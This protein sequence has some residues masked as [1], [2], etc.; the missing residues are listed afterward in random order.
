MSNEAFDKSWLS[1]RCALCFLRG[2]S[3]LQAPCVTKGRVHTQP[4]DQQ[5][6]RLTTFMET[7]GPL[8]GS[9][10]NRCPSFLQASHEMSTHSAESSAKNKIRKDRLK[11][12]NFWARQRWFFSLKKNLQP[13]YQPLAT[14]TW[15]GVIR[16]PTELASTNGLWNVPQ[17]NKINVSAL[18]SC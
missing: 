7:D 16:G 11:A 13:I 1:D 17:R 10:L 5:M 2:G 14:A 9:S 8:Q 4:S 12:P 15:F 3:G 18:E 6:G